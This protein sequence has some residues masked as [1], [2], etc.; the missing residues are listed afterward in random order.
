MFKIFVLFLVLILA[1][2]D[3]S[4]HLESEV[5]LPCS[6]SKAKTWA[7]SHSL[8]G[9]CRRNIK[10]QSFFCRDE[11]TSSQEEMG[12][13]I[14]NLL[15]TATRITWQ[16]ELTDAFLQSEW[17]GFKVTRQWGWSAHPSSLANISPLWRAQL[18]WSTRSRLLTREKWSIFLYKYSLK[19]ARLGE[20]PSFRDSFSLSTGSKPGVQT[21]LLS[22]K[23]IGKW[24]S[25]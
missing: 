25:T 7:V 8:V 21:D 22:L 1:S 11:S 16:C 10:K 14:L 3:H 5:P 6:T 18:A 19:L 13:T 17:A 12:K 15:T 2:S 9:V 23:F 20:W 24:Y 4:R